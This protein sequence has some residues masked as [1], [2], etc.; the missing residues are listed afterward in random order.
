M[1]SLH[2][3][4]SIIV[5]S[6]FLFLTGVSGQTKQSSQS[7]NPQAGTI[8]V[9]VGLVQTDVMVFDKQ[10]RFMPDLKMDQFEL[11]ID[12]K[13]QPI[14]FFE[15]V[16]A[17]S[18]HDEGIWAKAGNRTLPPAESRI[19]TNPGRTLLFFV[20]DWH[21]SED[22][23]MRSRTALSNLINTSVDP[24]DKVAIFRRRANLDQRKSSRETNP[25]CS[26]SHRSS[27]FKAPVPKTYSFLR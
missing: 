22:S 19:A 1:H 17:G 27:I 7:P 14:E 24:N 26:L 11:R 18:A 3:F 21:L 8:R 4:A 5:L 16:S 2:R 13:V 10:G 6:F 12:G 20:D 9:N 25:N 15:M 23:V